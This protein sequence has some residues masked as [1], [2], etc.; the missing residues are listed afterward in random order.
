MGKYARMCALGERDRDRE[1]DRE[2]TERE[3]RER[4]S[5]QTDRQIDEIY[6]LIKKTVSQDRITVG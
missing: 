4:E 3:Q 1:T 5:E 6:S 2:R